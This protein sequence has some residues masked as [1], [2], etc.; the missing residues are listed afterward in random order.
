MTWK[1]AVG[2]NNCGFRRGTIASVLFYNDL[3]IQQ[4]LQ[5]SMLVM[6]SKVQVNV[7]I[8]LI[9]DHTSFTLYL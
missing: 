9:L 1:L 7:P 8:L 6:Y 5:V 2:E 4:V 3:F